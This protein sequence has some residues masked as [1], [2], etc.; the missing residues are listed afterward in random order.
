MKALN[1][2]RMSGREVLPLI[3]GGKG[4]SATN[5]V[6]S[7]VWASTG[8]IGTVSG[9]NADS[10][11]DNGNVIRQVYKSKIRKER[12]EEMV[13]YA[14][15]GGI[16]QVHRAHEVAGGKGALHLNVLWE[17]GGAVRI[18][19]GILEKTK[20]LIHGVTC[21]AG[22]PYRVAQIAEKYNIY[23]YPIVSSARA[24][25]ALWLR[26]YKKVPSLLGGVVYEDPWRAGGHNGLSNVEDPLKPEDP[27]PRV[28]LLRKQMNEYGLND[29]P[30]IMAGGV[31]WLC[32]WENWLDNPEIG[33]IA[34]QFGTRPLLT[35]ESPIPQSWKDRL[36]DVKKGDVALNKFSPT[37][38]YSSAVRNAF[39]QELYDRS[40]RQIVYATEATDVL[41]ESFKTGPV[42]NPVFVSAD[43]LLK[44]KAWIEAGFSKAMRTP[45]ST[46]VFETPE[47]ARLVLQ[48][49]ANCMGCLS[50][51]LFSNWAENEEGTT[52][53]M[54]DPRSFCIQKSL[55]NVAHE[56][57]MDDFLMFAGHNCYRF[58]E[59]PFYANKFVPTVKQLVEQ[60]LTGK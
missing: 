17:M 56:G 48:D 19:E 23:Y 33:P 10:Y 46:L 32:E 6:S 39:L 37:G 53:R 13:T 27:Y 31:W 25:R 14:I 34:F 47:I 57:D 2:V 11:D 50:Q 44:A 15:S 12:H 3:E 24:F 1:A 16:A 49:Q 28:A 8:G 30:I 40:A 58:S 21:G 26:S 18:L 60:I 43:D 42:G 22:M 41:T 9:V 45:D 51:C 54:A 20:G 35:V 7:G 59:D 36:F 55:Q 5:G 38:F 4:V 29:T 52:G